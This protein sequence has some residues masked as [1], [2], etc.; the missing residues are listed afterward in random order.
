LVPGK[1]AINRIFFEVGGLDV[2]A[3]VIAI[4]FG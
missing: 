4:N 1:P 2:A 3:E